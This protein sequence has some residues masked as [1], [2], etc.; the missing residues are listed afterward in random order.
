[1]KVHKQKKNKK[2]KIVLKN[3]SLMKIPIKY[4]QYFN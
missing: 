2:N 3:V 1:M 4:I